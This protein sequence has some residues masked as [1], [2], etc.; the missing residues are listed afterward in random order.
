MTASDQARDG[1]LP[2]LGLLAGPARRTFVRG[3]M[4]TRGP[5]ARRLTIAVGVVLML[6]VGVAPSALAYWHSTGAGSGVATAGTL[7]APAA[8]TASSWGGTVTVS[9]AAATPPTGALAGYTVIRYAGATPSN[10]CGTDPASS[11]T[12]I[13]VGTLTCADSS[14]AS[15][16]YTY[17]V[18]AV[19]R[20]WTAGSLPSSAVTVVVPGPLQWFGDG[21]YGQGGVLD[22]TSERSP[23]PEATGATT[24]VTVS[25]AYGH[26]CGTRTD[27]TLWCWGYNTTGQLGIGNIT[28]RTSPTQ[29]AGTTWGTVATGGGHTCA[30]KTGGTLWCWGYNNY[31]EVGIGSVVTPQTS[32]VQVGAL[33]T[34]ATVTAGDD[35][36]CATK[37]GG[38]LW[39]WGYNSNGQLGV[40][41]VAQKNSPTQVG[42]LTTWATADAGNAHTCATKT[43]ATLWC[44]GSNTKGQLGIGSLVQQTSPTQVGALTTWATV[45]AGTGSSVQTHTCATKTDATLWCWGDNS[46]GQLGLGSTTQQTSPTQVGALTTW[47]TVATGDSHGCA[48]KTDG[49]LWCWGM[50]GMGQL[51]N[52]QPRTTTTAQQV[53]AASTWTRVS[54]GAQHTCATRSDHTLWC[55][56]DNPWGQLGLGSTA[57]TSQPTQ[58]GALATWKTVAAGYQHTCATKTDGTLWCWGQNFYGQLGGGALASPQVNPVKVGVLTTWASVTTGAY[59]TCATKTDGTLWCWGDNTFGE[60][61]IGSTVL[62]NT[63]NRVGAAI[64]TWRSVSAG[65]LHTCA[66]QTDGTLWCWGYNG[67]GQVGNGT[68]VWPQ[69][70][71]AQVGP[72]VTTWN[73]VQSGN[74]HTCATRTDGTLWCWG[75]NTFGQVGIG[76]TVTPQTS[77]V[78]VG[79]LTTWS[80][81]APGSTHTCATHDDYT[82]WCWGNNTSGQLGL[83]DTT[84]RD[85]PTQVPGVTAG[86]LFT[87]DQANSTFIVS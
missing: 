57:N 31:G 24:W 62:K 66:T 48:T 1:R 25:G 80:M 69:T 50:G 28:Q 49:T 67:S 27:H 68:V 40:G 38:T 7:A 63:P 55:W 2:R 52:G 17:T 79:A 78:Q 39:C 73:S 14:V 83:G 6:T 22:F 76:S 56:G 59:H 46:W 36:T 8:V 4:G 47:N 75:D 58:V 45:A 29:V 20:S 15:G 65:S 82:V 3:R 21:A 34:W 18:T 87:G 30:I 85:S 13:P 12:F 43:D 5:R 51:G 41:S 74:T 70:S 60:L 10:A 42:L 19:W 33:T 64:V 86:G 11:G 53:G 32:P 84:E 9:W 71:P 61:G 37:T 35:H 81:L 44:W 77:P 26:T 72:G 16:T 54:S 23:G